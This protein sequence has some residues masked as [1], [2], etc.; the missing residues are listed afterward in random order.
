MWQQPRF[1]LQ[2]VACRTLWAIP[3]RQRSPQLRPFRGL[4]GEHCVEAFMK[5]AWQGC[6]FFAQL[7]SRLASHWLKSSVPP[8]WY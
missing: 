4:A 6:L 8:Y 3:Q 7:V 2:H 5:C 1:T